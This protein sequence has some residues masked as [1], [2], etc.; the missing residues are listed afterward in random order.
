MLRQQRYHNMQLYINQST[1]QTRPME[2]HHGDTW[3]QIIFRQ[4]AIASRK[5][6]VYFRGSS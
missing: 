2:W 1:L 5:L 4:P 6:Y 3:R